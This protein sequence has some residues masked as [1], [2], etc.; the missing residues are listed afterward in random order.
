[1]KA[2]TGR[3]RYPIF[4]RKKIRQRLRY[5]PRLGSRNFTP[6]FAEGYSAASEAK[7]WGCPRPRFELPKEIAALLD[8]QQKLSAI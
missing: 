3:N 1:V 7:F 2:L 4:T 8:Q 6:K 5:K